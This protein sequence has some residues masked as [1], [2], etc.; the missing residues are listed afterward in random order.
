MA[1]LSGARAGGPRRTT[2]ARTPY[3]RPDTKQ[4]TFIPTGPTHRQAV[5]IVDQETGEMQHTM[6]QYQAKGWTPLFAIPDGDPRR[7]LLPRNHQ[8]MMRDHKATAVIPFDSAKFKKAAKELEVELPAEDES[9]Q[10][11]AKAS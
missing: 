11:P 7:D 5:E 6:D 3:W 2:V 10:Q 9:E 8:E 1:R 4:W